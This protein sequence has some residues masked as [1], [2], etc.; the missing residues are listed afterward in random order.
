MTLATVQWG[1]DGHSREDLVGKL[2]LK[3]G[4]WFFLRPI[5]PFSEDGKVK[6]KSLKLL[7]KANMTDKSRP[8]QCLT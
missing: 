2:V 4:W 8:N 3:H 5:N 6:N 7:L 1:V